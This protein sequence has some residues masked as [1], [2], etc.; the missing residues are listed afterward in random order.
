MFNFIENLYFTTIIFC[1]IKKVQNVITVKAHGIKVEFTKSSGQDNSAEQY[2][3]I[4][5]GLVPEK[6]RNT[7]QKKHN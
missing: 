3:Q 1:F 6:K 5:L 4:G 7:T 2:V